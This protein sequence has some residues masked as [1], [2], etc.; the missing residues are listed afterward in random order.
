MEAE[1]DMDVQEV[2]D[3]LATDEGRWDVFEQTLSEMTP[4]YHED[5][6]WLDIVR[7]NIS[8]AKPGGEEI[9]VQADLPAEMEPDVTGPDILR[10]LDDL[11]SHEVEHVNNSDLKA[12][13]RMTDQYQNF[14]KLAGHVYNIFEDEYIDMRRKVRYY[15]MRSKL[16]YYVWLHMNTPSRAPDVGEVEDEEGTLNAIMTGLLEVALSGTMNGEPSDEVADAI[17]RIEPLIEKVRAMAKDD[18]DNRRDGVNTKRDRE[19]LVHT[20][21]QIILRYVPDPEEYDGD[22]MDDRKR[23]TGGDPDELDDE[24]PSD[25]GGDPRF[26]MD[27]SME[28]AVEE[29]LEDMMDDPDTPDPVPGEPE[30]LEPEDLEPDEDELD[31]VEDMLDDAMDDAESL[32][33]ALDDAG[34]GDAADADADGGERDPEEMDDETIDPPGDMGGAGSD[35]D[36]SPG[37]SLD[38]DADGDGESGSESESESESGGRDRDI[39]ALVEEYGVDALTV[40]D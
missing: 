8:H 25:I 29:M 27:S 3:E 12:K 37:D 14:G 39:A 7:A 2:L 16:A 35:G 30:V 31:D 17:A 19:V 40:R 20:A 15:G 28:D 36:P 38:E 4:I 22:K 24:S 10:L 18:E 13:Q 21:I 34:D 32:D 5:N 33:D 9:G 26:D 6:E 23:A 11:T 1:T